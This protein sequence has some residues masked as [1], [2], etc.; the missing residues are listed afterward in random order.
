MN[1]ALSNLRCVIADLTSECQTLRKQLHERGTNKVALDAMKLAHEAFELHGNMYPHMVKGYTL[2]AKNVLFK[3]IQELEKP[4]TKEAKERAA[5]RADLEAVRHLALDVAGAAA[6]EAAFTEFWGFGRSDEDGSMEQSCWD[7]GLA[8]F[9][10]G[11][12]YWRAEQRV[13]PVQV[14]VMPAPNHG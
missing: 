14:P 13:K 9:T 1:D 3:A 6:I 12:M 8:A 5:L 4:L 10:A 7:D 11:V 2:D